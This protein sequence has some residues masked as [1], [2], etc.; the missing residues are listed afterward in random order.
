MQLNKNLV[1]MFLIVAVL[2]SLVIVS[3]FVPNSLIGKLIIHFNNLSSVLLMILTLFYV[4]TT[5]LQLKAMNNQISLMRD[6]TNMQVQPIPIPIIENMKLEKIKPFLGPYDKS[7]KILSRFFCDFNFKNVGN[8]TA[9][10]VVIFPTIAIG[11]TMIPSPL[12][13]PKLTYCISNEII[14]KDKIH[15]MMYDRDTKIAEAIL[16][17]EA[18]FVLNIFYKNIFNV[19]FHELI[20]YR[21]YL[22]KKP[23]KWSEFFNSN[24]DKLYKEINKHNAIKPI[25]K[26]EAKNIF[27]KIKEELNELFTEDLTVQYQLESESYTIDIVDYVKAVKTMETENENIFKNIFKDKYEYIMAIEKT[28]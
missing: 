15:I 3:Y 14:E 2:F 4:V 13:Q 7:M 5:N 24:Q 22:N 6:N 16:N 26:E 9:L 19:G 28:P 25:D 11:N 23:D 21:L 12:M 17:N 8:G 18:K 27:N 1:I 20:S 10:N